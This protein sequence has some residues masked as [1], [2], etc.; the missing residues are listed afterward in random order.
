MAFFY[1]F[2]DSLKQKWLQFYASNRDW[3]KLHMEVDSVYTPD[4]GKRP[5]SYLILGVA[6]A[7]EPKLAQLMLPF[8]KL[9][10]DADTLIEVLDL[11]FDPDTELGEQ[12][13]Q[14][15]SESQEES[16]TSEFSVDENSDEFAGVATFGEDAHEVENIA[17]P[18]MDLGDSHDGTL[19][20]EEAWGGQELEE[21][22]S[23]EESGLDDIQV[24][25]LG[26]I[27]ESA[28]KSNDKEPQQNLNAESEDAFGD[29][30]FDEFKDGDS[31]GFGDA[32]TDVWSE[33]SA[34]KDNEIFSGEDMSD[35]SIDDSEIA[36]LFPNS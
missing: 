28:E 10:A 2:T 4:G 11:H 5:S 23:T 8:S 1:S 35:G 25:G 19:V 7:L 16:E 22:F 36:R 17:A 21:N 6:N 18:D 27:S 34:Q 30:S 9:N 14:P 31:T 33:E 29:I 12:P 15:E 13:I 24:E 26:D 20:V 3:I 32:L